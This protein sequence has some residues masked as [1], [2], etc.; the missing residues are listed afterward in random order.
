MSFRLNLS[1]FLWISAACLGLQVIP[2]QVHSENFEEG[3]LTSRNLVLPEM[4][5]FR[6]GAKLFKERDKKLAAWKAFQT[7]L[8]NYPESPL[9]ADAQYMLG[10]SIFAQSVTDLKAGNAPDEQT[11]KKVKKGG[12]KML[13]KGFKKS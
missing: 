4:E 10:E 11:W 13:G 8:F 7:F 12:L 3:E 5:Q 2:A 9:A 6:L 1:R